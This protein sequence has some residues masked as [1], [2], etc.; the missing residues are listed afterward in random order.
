MKAG[1]RQGRPHGPLRARYADLAILGQEDPDDPQAH[2][3]TAIAEQVLFSSG[4]PILMVPYVGQFAQVGRR[5]LIGWNAQREAARAIHDAVPLIRNAAVVTVV[6]VDP[7][8]Q[9]GG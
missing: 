2:G 4:R 6:A 1:R 3:W 9:P 5:V 7:L 8:G